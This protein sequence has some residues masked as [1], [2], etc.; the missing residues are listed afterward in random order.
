MAKNSLARY[1]EIADASPVPFRLDP[2]PFGL[3]AAAL[4]DEEIA[5]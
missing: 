2:E 5:R 4:D 1:L 3:V